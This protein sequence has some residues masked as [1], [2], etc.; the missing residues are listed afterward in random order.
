M[1]LVFPDFITLANVLLGTLAIMYIL[2][3]NCNLGIFLIL[4]CIILDGIDGKVARAL[5]RQ[6]EL[7][8][9]LDSLADSVSFCLAPAILLYKSYY[10]LERGSAFYNLE[11]AIVIIV[12]VFVV[13]F[14]VLR[15]ARF[16]Y[17]KENNLRFF[18]GLPTPALAFFIVIL[19]NLLNVLAITLPIG[20]ISFLMLS[21]LKYPKIEGLGYTAGSLV[22]LLF[23]ALSFIYQWLGVIP[24]ALILTYIL[25]PLFQQKSK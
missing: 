18:I 25:T 3:G 9:Y 4:I 6:R 19:Y 21:K 10:S 15:L 11:N 1:K 24:L 12:I 23:G 17:E 22:A 14:G 2:D 13:G 8:R 16:A 5:R 7:G 20:I